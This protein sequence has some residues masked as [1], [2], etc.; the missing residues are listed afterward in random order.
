MTEHRRNIMVLDCIE[1]KAHYSAKEDQHYQFNKDLRRTTS[2]ERACA[3][4]AEAY[5]MRSEELTK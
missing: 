2:I 1:A 3:V 4:I 5:L